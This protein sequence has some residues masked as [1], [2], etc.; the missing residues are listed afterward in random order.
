MNRPF[1]LFLA[2]RKGRIYFIWMIVILALLANVLQPFGLINIHEFHKPLVL[3]DYIL[4]FYG[5]YALLYTVLSYFSPRHYHP[6]TWT[7]K[8]EF[9]ALMFYIPATAGTTY[10]FA[11]FSVPEFELSLPS[12]LQLQFYNSLLTAISIPTFGYFVDTRLNPTTIAQRLKRKENAASRLNLNEKQSRNILQ[13]LHEV[14]ETEQLYLS[15]KCSLQHVATRSG[16]P[17]HHISYAINT[18]TEYTF[19]DF[20]NKY[21]VEHV[22]RILQNGPDKKLKMEGIGTECGFGSKVS[23]YAA[24]R[25]FTAKTPTEYLTEVKLTPKP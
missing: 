23:F 17:L 9:R 1:P 7:I 21:R 15:I 19:N 20:V 24:F 16:I 11:D 2:H 4:V 18:F 25:K 14:M 10:L 5:T 6:D 3:A 22:C 12:F 8:K 13:K